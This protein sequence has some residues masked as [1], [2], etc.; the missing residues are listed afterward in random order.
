MGSSRL[1][2]SVRLA[3]PLLVLAGLSACI[4]GRLPAREYYR[5]WVVDSA[6]AD[7]AVRVPVAR[8]GLDGV[9]AVADYET[10]G[11][12]GN[13]TIVYRLDTFEYGVYP[14]RE[15]AVPLGE[16]LGMMTERIARPRSLADEVVH[17]PPARQRAAY[18]WRGLVREFEEVDRGQRVFGS[19]AL[20]AQLIR[21]SDDS[22]V[23]SGSA[24]HEAPA[25][26]PRSMRSVV[27]ALS[28]AATRAVAALVDQAAAATRPVPAALAPG[29]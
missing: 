21:A 11:I 18:V 23:W 1:V 5:L 3:A 17:D 14:S 22:V 27:E 8:I 24:Q 28:V 15:W 6:A 29:R 13:G 12:Y 10:P 16:M 19:V 25:L 7:S 9:I 2:A 4:R 26:D 20:T